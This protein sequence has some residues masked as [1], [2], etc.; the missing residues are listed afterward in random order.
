MLLLHVKHNER[1]VLEIR[2]RQIRTKRPVKYITQIKQVNGQTFWTCSQIIAI[3][4][5]VVNSFYNEMYCLL[6]ISFLSKTKMVHIYVIVIRKIYYLFYRNIKIGHIPHLDI[7]SRPFLIVCLATCQNNIWWI[8]HC[9]KK[10][11]DVLKLYYLTVLKK[12]GD[13]HSKFGVSCQFHFTLNHNLTYNTV[14][15]RYFHWGA[16]YYWCILDLRGERV[17]GICL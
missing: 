8:K 16:N 11:S 2:L 3:R 6:T 1:S 17:E 10:F 12:S 13:Y 14:F 9:H 15:T 5:E 7:K 4:L